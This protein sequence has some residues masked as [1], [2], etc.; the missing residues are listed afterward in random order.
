MA[1]SPKPVT[2][3]GRPMLKM[4][5]LMAAT[6]LP[7]S[8]LLLYVNKGLL[9]RPLK[10]SPNMAYYHPDSVERIGFIRKIQALHRLP[11]AAIKGLLK[12]MD[13][14]RD[15]APLLELQSQIFDSDTDRMDHAAFC[16]ASGLTPD[17]LDQLCELGL[18]LPLEPD[19]F[20]GQDVEM[21]KILGEMAD[22]GMAMEEL[23][24]YPEMARTIVA[25]ELDLREKYT[26]NL[27]DG[28]NASLTVEMTRMARSLRAYVIDRTLQKRLIQYKGLKPQ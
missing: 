1:Q 8:T 18:I 11:L 7:K 13:Q 20:D 19:L 14:G 3:D 9:P 25:R 21:G 17:L 15:I 27:N 22:R 28:D 23:A 24:F 2:P 4:K 26:R 10:T 5:Q 16:K 6:G 12:E